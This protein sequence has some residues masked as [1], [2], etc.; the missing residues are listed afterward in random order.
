MARLVTL[1]GITCLAMAALTALTRLEN[2]APTEQAP[3]E[4]G[5]KETRLTAPRADWPSYYARFSL[6]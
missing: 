1:L 3:E 4:N 2:L 6:N 5:N